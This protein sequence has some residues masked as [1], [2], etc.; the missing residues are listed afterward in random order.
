MAYIETTDGSSKQKLVRSPQCYRG[1]KV[2]CVWTEKASFQS[3]PKLRQRGQG[4]DR[5]GGWEP[6]AL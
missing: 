6:S 5:V 2:G 1:E 4:Q 3:S